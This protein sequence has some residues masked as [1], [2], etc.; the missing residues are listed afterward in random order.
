MPQ[1]AYVR[2]PERRA[3]GI[4]SRAGGRPVHVMDGK[5]YCRVE[6]GGFDA[7]ESWLRETSRELNTDVLWLV[8]QKQADA[9]AFEHW[10]AGELK[11]RL[12]YGV[13]DERVWECVD[14]VAEAWEAD[15]FFSPRILERRLKVLQVIDMPGAQ[16]QDAI[17]ALER[18]WAEQR[19]E[20]GATEPAV[21]AGSVGPAVARYYDLPG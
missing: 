9:F 14:G 10:I 19:I 4:R 11:R 18:V 6:W 21:S 7:P 5:Q 1:D 17:E 13:E 16:R 2:I 8:F 15:A 20:V 12:T 3:E